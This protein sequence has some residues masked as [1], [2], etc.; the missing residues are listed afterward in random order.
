[1]LIIH[2]FNETQSHSS[3]YRSLAQKRILLAMTAETH[4]E[5][6]DAF[7]EYTRRLVMRFPERCWTDELGNTC[8]EVLSTASDVAERVDQGTLTEAQAEEV[9]ERQCA[10]IGRAC[11]HGY[12]PEFPAGHCGL[13]DTRH[14]YSYLDSVRDVLLAY[15]AAAQDPV[16][17]VDNG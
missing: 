2:P 14:K 1:M 11:I 6:D 7:D 12:T 13:D 5:S 4:F 15:D 10:I 17:V 8:P 9:V 3:G 16:T